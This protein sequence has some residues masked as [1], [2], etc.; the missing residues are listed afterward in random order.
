MGGGGIK[1][2]TS[3]L[4][5]KRSANELPT[6]LHCKHSCIY[7][8]ITKGQKFSAVDWRSSLL[9]DLLAKCGNM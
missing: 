1:P 8:H 6:Q 2:P 7:R 3:H 5:S 9:T 4:H